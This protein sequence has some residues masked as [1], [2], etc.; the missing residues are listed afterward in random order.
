L[1]VNFGSDSTQSV[2]HTVGQN[3]LRLYPKLKKRIRGRGDKNSF[4]AQSVALSL[5]LNYSIG[6]FTFLPQLYL[7]YYLPK[8]DEKRFTQTF[9]LSVGYSF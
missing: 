9:T 8:T 1:L 7:D 2:S 3:L 6:N 5:D 4:E